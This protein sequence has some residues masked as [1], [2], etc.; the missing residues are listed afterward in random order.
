MDNT[1][2]ARKIYQSD[3]IHSLAKN[4]EACLDFR[5]HFGKNLDYTDYYCIS[6]TDYFYSFVLIHYFR[7]YQIGYWLSPAL[8]GKGLSHTYFC[9]TFCLLKKHKPEYLFAVIDKKNQPSQKLIVHFG[10]SM[11]T[12]CGNKEIFAWYR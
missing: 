5:C 2:E 1:I 11:M 4:S 8:R 6:G 12:Q 7:I 9:A 3:F 10:F